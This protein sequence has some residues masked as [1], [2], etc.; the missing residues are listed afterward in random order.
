MRLVM[1]DLVARLEGLHLM[2]PTDWDHSVDFVNVDGDLLD[3]CTRRIAQQCT[4]DRKPLGLA[5]CYGC[6]HLL[7]T[8]SLSTNPVA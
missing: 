4:F 2:I 5:V 7:R 1:V 3:T 8:P 6:G